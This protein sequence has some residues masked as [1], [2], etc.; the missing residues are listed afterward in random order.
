MAPM[1]DWDSSRERV[2]ADLKRLSAQQEKY[3]QAA[4]ERHIELLEKVAGVRVDIAGLKGRAAVWGAVT[5]AI[6]SGLIGTAFY[7]MRH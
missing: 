4:N 7:A 5:A 3:E 2:N 1:G 6:V